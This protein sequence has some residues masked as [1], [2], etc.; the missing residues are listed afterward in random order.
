M[1][2]KI[3]DYALWATY[4]IAA[5]VVTLDLTLWRTLPS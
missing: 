2:S 4:A 5:I 1:K 3:Q